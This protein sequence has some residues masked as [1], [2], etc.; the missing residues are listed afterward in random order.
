MT[1]K[2]IPELFGSMVFNDKAMKEYL[3]EEAYLA[4]KKTIEN[5]KSLDKGA[6][7]YPFHPLVPADDRDHG[8]EA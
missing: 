7:R 2:K 3:P 4:L 1:A 8:R 5:G 6:G